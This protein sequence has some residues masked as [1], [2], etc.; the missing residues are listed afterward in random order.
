MATKFIRAR[1]RITSFSLI[2]AMIKYLPKLTQT[3]RETNKKASVI[4]RGALSPF[5]CLVQDET[6]PNLNS[7][8]H[9]KLE[10]RYRLL[11]LAGQEQAPRGK[12]DAWD[13]KK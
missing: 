13:L 8:L 5:A 12:A 6:V 11:T 1:G 4:T 7:E 3:L 2:F 10:L 9:G